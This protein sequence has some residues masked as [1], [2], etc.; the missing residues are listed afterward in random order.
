MSRRAT[1]AD[2]DALAD[3]IRA[4]LAD[5]GTLEVKSMFGSRVFMLDGAMVCCAQ[6]GGNLLVRVDGSR[7]DELLA[8]PGAAQAEMD[9]GRSMGP[10]WITVDAAALQDDPELRSWIDVALE[11]H[12]S[13]G[14]AP[15]PVKGR[16]R[17][18]SA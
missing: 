8:R 1:D 17:S 3:R 5:A 2:R 16:R 11:R 9:S 18:R 14:P 4:A 13:A 15:A 7:S 12:R 6:R 10:S